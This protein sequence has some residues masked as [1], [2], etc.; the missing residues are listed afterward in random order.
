VVGGGR[1]VEPEKVFR[2]TEK[3]FPKIRQ[4]KTKGKKPNCGAPPKQRGGVE[5]PYKHPHRGA[6]KGE[7][8]EKRGQGAQNDNLGNSLGAKGKR[9]RIATLKKLT[10]L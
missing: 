4:A 2:G 7:P 9:K 3:L 5:E 6:I 1:G 10:H 8:N